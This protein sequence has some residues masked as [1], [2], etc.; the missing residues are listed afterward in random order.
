MK[1]TAPITNSSNFYSVVWFGKSDV[2]LPLNEVALV[3]HSLFSAVGDIITIRA[4]AE[5]LE[6]FYLESRK[7]GTPSP[8]LIKHFPRL[9]AGGLQYVPY[10][11]ENVYTAFPGDLVYLSNYPW[12]CT[13]EIC[14][15][16]ERRYRGEVAREKWEVV[17][18]DVNEPAGP[19][20]RYTGKLAAI[21]LS[22]HLNY[23][24]DSLVEKLGKLIPLP[25]RLKDAMK[26][27]RSGK[28]ANYQ[29][30]YDNILIIGYFC[31]WYAN[32]LVCGISPVERQ[33]TEIEDISDIGYGA[34]LLEEWKS[35][36]QSL[37]IGYL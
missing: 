19:S 4:S 8:L 28:F 29:I 9:K 21:S 3:A 17:L 1:I 16:M 25:P 14:A 15:R 18:I 26:I 35:G 32:G 6:A 24:W 30:F 22:D 20:R 33:N 12:S 11:G 7:S 31:L 37:C 36:K 13:D 27:L 23:R 10:A 2:H 5:D 34:Q